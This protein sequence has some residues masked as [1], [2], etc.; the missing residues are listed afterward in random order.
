[1]T[2]AVLDPAALPAGSGRRDAPVTTARAPA[3]GSARAAPAR[4]GLSQSGLLFLPRRFHRNEVIRWLK[5]VHAW[6]GLWGAALFLMMG[7]SGF[8]LNHR[9]TVA[10]IDT[11]APV[12]VSAVDMAVVPGSI[13][14]DKALAAFGRDRLGLTVTPRAPRGGAKPADKPGPV[15]M[16]GRTIAPAAQAP[17]PIVQEFPHPNGTVTLSHV[18]GSAVVGV[19]QDAVN[20]LGVIKNLHKGTG[21][22]IGWI[23]LFDTIAGALIV[24]ALTGTLLWTRLHGTRLAAVTIGGGALVWALLAGTP[25]FL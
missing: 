2:D 9:T 13:A 12:E 17:A 20:V 4:R 8:L 22:G 7:T 3:P 6:T 21:M 5:R 11:G 14:N 10:K 15:A 18:P 19:R 24:M 16:L 25:S 1:M 23:L